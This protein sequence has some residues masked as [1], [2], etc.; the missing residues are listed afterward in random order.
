MATEDDALIRRIRTGDQNA[1]AELMERYRGQLLAT[2]S[3]KMSDLLKRS[4][5]P[6]DVVQEA[7]TYCLKTFAE[8]DCKALDPMPWV[9]QVLERKIVDAH[10][11]HAAQ[12][13]AAD[14][15]VP[16]SGATDSS[17]GLIDLLIASI[18]SASQA[19]ARNRREERLMIAMQQLTQEQQDALRMRYVENLPSKEIADKLGKSDG[20]IRV[21]LTRSLRQLEELLDDGRME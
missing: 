2:A 12:K 20:A 4:V 10:R 14:K 8:I 21:M 17:P 3:R 5:E 1:L 9:H 13:R 15:G 16:L 18:T 19:F 6:D 7:I 11:H